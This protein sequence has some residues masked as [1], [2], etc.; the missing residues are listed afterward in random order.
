MTEILLKKSRLNQLRFSGLAT[1]I[2]GLAVPQ[3]RT[4]RA[5]GNH[6]TRTPPNAT[7]LRHSDATLQT[8]GHDRRTPLACHTHTHA[9]TPSLSMVTLCIPR[10]LHNN[11]TRVAKIH[12]N[13]NSF[14]RTGSNPR[15]RRRDSAHNGGRILMFDSTEVGPVTPSLLPAKLPYTVR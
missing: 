14:P 11:I 10:L 2:F 12:R 5:A 9:R 13:H 1:F 7:P 8:D 3:G 15:K 4:F 6:P